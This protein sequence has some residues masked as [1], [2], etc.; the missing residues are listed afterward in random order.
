MRLTKQTHPLSWTEVFVQIGAVL[1]AIYAMLPDPLPA[2]GPAWI[3]LGVGIVAVAIVT[4][5]R[6]PVLCAKPPEDPQS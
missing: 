5:S 1:T 6:S 2:W 3:R 4:V